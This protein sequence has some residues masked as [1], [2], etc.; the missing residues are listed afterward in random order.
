MSP[1]LVCHPSSLVGGVRSIEAD[2]CWP[3]IDVLR[4]RFRLAGDVARIRI[5]SPAAPRSTPGLWRHTCFEAFLRV[6]GESAYH[7][8]NFSP[9]GEWAAHAFRGYRDGGLISEET[10]APRI[11]SRCATRAFE[12]DATVALDRLAPPRRDG[13]LAIGLCAVVEHDSGALSYWALHHPRAKPD[14]H[15]AAGFVLRLESPPR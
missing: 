13:A 5:P 12:L 3:A 11:R 8:L 2:A 10:L 4:F 9:S 15:D 1:F 14:F 7:E 6:E